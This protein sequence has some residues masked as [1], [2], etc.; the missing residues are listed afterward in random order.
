VGGAVSNGT[1]KPIR[2]SSHARG[3]LARRGFTEAEVSDAIRSGHW[4]ATHSGRWESSREFPYN[5]D[6]N[7]TFYARKRV[8]PIFAEEATEI[9]VVTVYTYFF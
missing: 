8:R 4:R 5:S 7:G 1:T 9:V 3:Y 2:L 6:W